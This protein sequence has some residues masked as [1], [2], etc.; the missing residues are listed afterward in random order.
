ML[1]GVRRLAISTLLIVAVRLKRVKQATRVVLWISLT[2]SMAGAYTKLH[3]LAFSSRQSG[4]PT[5]IEII[6]PFFSSL[7][8]FIKASTLEEAMTTMPDQFQR[9]LQAIA[10][11][12]TKFSSGVD[13]AQDG[14]GLQLNGSALLDRILICRS[15]DLSTPPIFPVSR[16][17]TKLCNTTL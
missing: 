10:I 6:L 17:A 3:V 14:S 2:H 1:A 9:A 7:S 16:T 15:E 5:E 4:S 13:P 8:Q 12:V 11:N